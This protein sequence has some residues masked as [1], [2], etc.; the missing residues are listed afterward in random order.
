MFTISEAWGKTYPKAKVAVM[1]MSN[2]INPAHRPENDKT[3][4]D[5]QNLL[6]ARFSRLFRSDLVKL[7]PVKAYDAYY[8]RFNRIY[9]LHYQLETVVYQERGKAKISPFTEVVF[10]NDVQNMLITYCHDADEITD[11]LVLD[12]AGEG[13]R[14]TMDNGK[15]FE[16]PKGDM[17]IRDVQG[18]ISSLFGGAAFHTRVT[19]DTRRVMLVLY[20]PPGLS[21]PTMYH[22]LF[23]IHAG[24]RRYS[25]AAEINYFRILK[26]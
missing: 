5:M 22:H 24:L 16:I 1:V 2:I 25:P 18:T 4:E 8:K 21:E 11:P 9:D 20:G 13:V 10:T 17:I 15:E 23:D 3:R 14:Y 12:V 7:G 26:R 6:R 19:S